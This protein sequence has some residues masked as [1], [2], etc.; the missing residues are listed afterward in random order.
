MLVA[1]AGDR[2]VGGGRF[3]VG[4]SAFKG[5]LEPLNALELL[6]LF[7]ADDGVRAQTGCAARAALG[8]NAA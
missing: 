4:L 8:A 5:G 6:K 1:L 2:I 7:S 3:L